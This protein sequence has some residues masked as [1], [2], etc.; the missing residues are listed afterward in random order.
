MTYT[1]KI[2]RMDVVNT[3]DVQDYVVTAY[4]EYTGIDGEYSASIQGACKYE[5]SDENYVAYSDLDEATVIG[6]VEESLTENGV[7]ANKKKLDVAINKQKN[8]AQEAA[9]RELPWS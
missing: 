2:T 9:E 8:V 5:V 4:Y 3:A 6:W 7:A 1:Y